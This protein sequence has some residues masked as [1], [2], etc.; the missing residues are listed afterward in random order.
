[1]R[2]KNQRPHQSKNIDI[3]EESSISCKL[4]PIELID[5]EQDETLV[6]MEQVN[7]KKFQNDAFESNKI[8]LKNIILH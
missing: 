8:L 2:T 5:D 6:N 4:E 7:N 3:I 1:M